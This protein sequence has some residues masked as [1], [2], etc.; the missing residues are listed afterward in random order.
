MTRSSPLPDENAGAW[1][2]TTL[3]IPAPAAVNLAVQP[4][5]DLSRLQPRSGPA[6]RPEVPPCARV[7]APEAQVRAGPCSPHPPG[8]TP[9]VLTTVQ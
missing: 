7:N 6:R 8:L 5:L 9:S 2:R 1:V 3:W 4:A